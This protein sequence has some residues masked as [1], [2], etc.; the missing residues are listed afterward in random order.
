MIT[1]GS[2]SQGYVGDFAATA[3]LDFRAGTWHTSSDGGR[4]DKRCNFS[5]PDN[6]DPLPWLRE[7]RR[8]KAVSI[9]AGES[10]VIS[11]PCT[12]PRTA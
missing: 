7:L 2:T 3:G 11:C 9:A 6:A 12:W 5:L 1:L 10:F 8:A 4:H